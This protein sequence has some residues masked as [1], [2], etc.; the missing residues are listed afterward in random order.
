MLSMLIGGH[1]MVILTLCMID[2]CSLLCIAD[3][4]RGAALALKLPPY[5][6]DAREGITRHFQMNR[7][8]FEKNALYGGKNIS[9][10]G[11]YIESGE[12]LTISNSLFNGHEMSPAGTSPISY[13][14]ALGIACRRCGLVGTPL[15]QHQCRV[16][17]INSNFT[18]NKLFV[19][20]EGGMEDGTT[21]CI[22]QS[23]RILSFFL[24]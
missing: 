2:C 11:M 16:I 13:G 14:N 1:S 5:L 3:T 4:A 6:H 18:S 22:I 8:T 7:S 17:I 10:A 20:T 23:R 15:H 24:L 21:F 9:G 19:G 12:S